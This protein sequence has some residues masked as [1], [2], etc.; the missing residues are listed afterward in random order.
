MIFGGGEYA[1][2]VNYFFYLKL[3]QVEHNI[4]GLNCP[5][6]ATSGALLHGVTK[7]P[8]RMQNR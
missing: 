8:L 5:F 7:F 2:L 1:A 3:K 6:V 4:T